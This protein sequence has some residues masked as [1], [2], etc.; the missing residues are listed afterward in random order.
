MSGW[1]GYITSRYGNP[2]NAIAFHNANNWYDQG[3]IAN[4]PGY[5]AKKT[6]EP[7]R[8]LSPVQTRSFERLVR[9]LEHGDVPAVPVFPN[10]LRLVVR[11]QEFDAYIEGVAGGVNDNDRAYGA[12]LSRMRS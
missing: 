3:G 9:T 1:V 4:G 5:F 11:G 6:L 7:E 10:K 12:K 2:A 8:V